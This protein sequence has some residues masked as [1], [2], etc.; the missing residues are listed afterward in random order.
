MTWTKTNV[1]VSGSPE[2][3]ADYMENRAEAQRLL[4]KAQRTI[5]SQRTLIRAMRASVWFAVGFML[6]TLVAL[7]IVLAVTRP[8]T[9]VRCACDQPLPEKP[10]P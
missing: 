2:A 1:E 4:D 5:E 8:D 3:V 6:L 9:V 7:P 10:T